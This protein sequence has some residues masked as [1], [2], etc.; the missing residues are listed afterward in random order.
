MDSQNTSSK[1]L[2][3][4]RKTTHWLHRYGHHVQKHRSRPMMPPA[5]GRLL[6]FLAEKGRIT[7]RSLGEEMNLRSASLSELLIKLERNGL[8]SRHP[9][10]EDKRTVDITLTREGNKMIEAI[11]SDHQDV[12]D[13]VFKALTVEESEQLYQLLGKLI[14]SWE[15]KLGADDFDDRHGFGAPGELAGDERAGHG[16][17]GSRGHHHHGC[18]DRPGARDGH[19]PDGRH[20]HHEFHGR[21]GA[22]DSHGPDDRHDHHEFHGREARDLSP[23][24]RP[25]TPDQPPARTENDD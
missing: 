10:A 18:H 3:M 5:Q 8:I 17:R 24:H 4:L 16:R 9:N 2:E 7:Q 20:D 12:A 13:E 6:N 19:G 25:Q 14:D 23:K 21:P 11:L 1:L 22:R 15:S